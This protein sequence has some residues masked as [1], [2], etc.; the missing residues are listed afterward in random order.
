M[1]TVLLLSVSGLLSVSTFVHAVTV[2]GINPGAGPAA[3]SLVRFDSATPGSVTNIGP[4]S[5]TLVDIDFYP[6]NGLL[7]GITSSGETYTIDINTAAL[8]LRFSP[9][10]A[11]TGLTDLD[12]NPVADR[13]RLFGDVDQNYRMVPDVTSA[14]SAPGTPGTVIADGTFSDT[15]RQLVGSAYTNNFDGATTT[16]LYSIDTTNDALM[17]HSGT[18]EFNT[19]AQVGAGL[20]A[21]IGTDVG[22]DIGQDGIAYGTDRGLGVFATIDLTTGVATVVGPLGVSVRTIAVAAIPEPG[23]TILSFA[24]LS[25]L[26]L[27]RRRKV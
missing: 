23:A 14:P 1:K 4:L 6:V 18:P 15:I 7:Y 19:I 8:T 9:L 16:T 17:I 5:A 11:L 10:T 22:F 25:L 24:G 26:A 27:R 13:M 21:P 3:D 20:G 12:F 2:Y